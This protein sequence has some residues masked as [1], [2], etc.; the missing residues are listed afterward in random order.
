MSEALIEAAGDR[1]QLLV[2]KLCNRLLAGIEF[3]QHGLAHLQWGHSLGLLI[4]VFRLIRHSYFLS[5]GAGSLWLLSP[6]Y[7]CVPGSLNPGAGCLLHALVSERVA[8]IVSPEKKF[9]ILLAYFYTHPQRD[10]L[11]R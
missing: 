6:Q 8:S 11:Q 4:L 5:F 1:L 9:I 7:F 10:S 2:A 3:G